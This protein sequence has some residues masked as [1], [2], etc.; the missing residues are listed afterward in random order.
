MLDLDIELPTI[1]I[2][3]NQPLRDLLIALP[4][5]GHYL[6]LVDNSMLEV[7]QRCPTA[8]LY[9]HVYRRQAYARNASLVFG[10]ALHRGIEAQLKGQPDSEQDSAIVKYFAEN[11]TPIDD[12]RSAPVALQVMKHYRARTKFDDYAMR[13]LGD[14]PVIE[15]PFEIPL[16]VLDVNT[17]IR[18]P[19]WPEPQHIKT[20]HVAWSGRIDAI[21]YT[22]FSNRIMDHKTTSIAG[23]TYTSSFMLSHQTIG[24]TWAARQLYPDLEVQGICINAIHLKRPYNGATL[25]ADLMSKGPRGGEPPLNF[26]RFFYDYSEE[27]TNEWATNC[28]TIIEDL[29]H[30]L[31]RNFYPMFT[32]H[33]INKFGRCE[34]HDVCT[35]DNIKARYKML[36]SESFEDVT[37]SPTK[38]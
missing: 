34:F 25:P 5:E 35:L 36:T 16:G 19:Y 21:V 28:M 17:D 11:P 4:E 32:H 3:T 2:P 23:D 22:M 8:F 6:L 13:I 15:R 12:Y 37:W 18:L 38:E 30:C 10:G 14:P 9:K 29:V 33:C 26:F 27:R 7:G 20:I 24:Y 1:S 31:V